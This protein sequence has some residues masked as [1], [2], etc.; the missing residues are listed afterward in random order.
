M[1]IAIIGILAAILLPA[2]ARAREAA[3]RSSCQN[4]LKQMG[5]VLKMYSNE[6]KGSFPPP[7]ITYTTT[8][9]PS[10]YGTSGSYPPATGSASL[11]CQYDTIYPEY[12]TDMNVIFCPSASSGGANKQ[13]TL[14]QLYDT[15]DDSFTVGGV[16]YSDGP[17]NDGRVNTN[18]CKFL[19][20]VYLGF[21]MTEDEH[22]AFAFGHLLSVSMGLTNSTHP[23]ELRKVMLGD[24]TTSPIM[25]VGMDFNAMLGL[26]AGSIV[27]AVGLNDGDSLPR[28]REGIERFMITDI[29]NPAASAQAQSEVPVCWDIVQQNSGSESGLQYFNHVPGGGNVLFMDGHVNFIRYP[30]DFPMTPSAAWIMSVYN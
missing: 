13:T 10:V 20:Y 12:L 27:P 26:P 25:D 28:L 15:N 16:E 9:M 11:F 3:R 23:D 21:V 30:G 24:A 17:Y 22:M 5:L 14:K 8:D 7:G 2:L 1:V 6:S 19:D 4:N 18:A 29:N